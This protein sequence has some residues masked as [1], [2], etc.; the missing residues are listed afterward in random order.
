M[1][2]RKLEAVLSEKSTADIEALNRYLAGVVEK[3][4]STKLVQLKDKVEKE[5]NARVNDLVEYIEDST[6]TNSN[7]WREAPISNHTVNK[8]AEQWGFEDDCCKNQNL[9]NSFYKTGCKNTRS[10][11]MP[12]YRGCTNKACLCTGEC[13]QIVGYR[14][15]FP[16]EI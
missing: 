3:N 7:F 9:N 12:V 14:T 1:N 16:G 4:A 11:I 6:S 10:H 8:K 5:L 15:K 2:T 13:K